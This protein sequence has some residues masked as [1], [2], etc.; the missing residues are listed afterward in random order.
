MLED[1]GLKI[2]FIVVRLVEESRETK[3]EEIEKDILKEASIPWS[4]VIE[5]VFVLKI[6]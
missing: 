4:N 2:A 3:N 5:K 1:L 6:G